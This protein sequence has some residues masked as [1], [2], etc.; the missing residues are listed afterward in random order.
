MICSTTAGLQCAADPVLGR[1]RRL[2][3]VGRAIDPTLVAVVGALAGAA[4][5]VAAVDAHGRRAEEP[6]RL[7]VL[8]RVDSTE[9]ELGPGLLGTGAEPEEES[10]VAGA[11][12][13]EEQL[14]RHVGASTLGVV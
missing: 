12:D 8:R 4:V 9:H 3:M 10:L 2:A 6:L 5:D 7:G 13:E 1:Y 14:D 11:A